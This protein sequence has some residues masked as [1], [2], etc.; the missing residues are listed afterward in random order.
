MIG[1]VSNKSSIISNK[2][3]DRAKREIQKKEKRLD[4][5]DLFS[6][7]MKG[8]NFEGRRKVH[9]SIGLVM[10]G[11]LITMMVAFTSTRVLALANGKNNS[12]MVKELHNQHNNE[13]EALSL[14]S[15]DFQIAFAV[16]DYTKG[17]RS[18]MK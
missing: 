14:D 6:T 8:F 18:L 7:Q 2:F 11:I 16:N 13:S 17:D 3:D 12:L 5:L 10:S 1:S 9:T 4:K 15:I